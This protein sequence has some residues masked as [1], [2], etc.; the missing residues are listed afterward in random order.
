VHLAS[1]LN[2]LPNANDRCNRD[3]WNFRNQLPIQPCRQLTAGIFFV[4]SGSASEII[5]NCRDFGA[6]DNEACRTL[7]FT[8]QVEGSIEAPLG[9]I[10]RRAR[11]TRLP[12]R[13]KPKKWR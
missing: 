10:R 4:L 9:S 11:K 6:S 13:W 5:A 1:W 2:R 7:S 12:I 3:R 8:F